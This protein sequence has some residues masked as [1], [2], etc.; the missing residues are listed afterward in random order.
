MLNS[1]NLLTVRHIQPTSKTFIRKCKDSNRGT[2]T[3]Y[4]HSSL[5]QYNKITATFKNR[6]NPHIFRRLCVK[7]PFEVNFRL[8]NFLNLHMVHKIFTV[9]NIKSWNEDK[10][11]L[12]N[13]ADNI[14]KI[15]YSTLCAQ[16]I[17]LFFFFHIE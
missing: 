10:I 1:T 5:V 7:A 13:I 16:N 2:H 15:S 3:S 12:L 17:L 11:E 6:G 14:A 4:S 8:C 9:I